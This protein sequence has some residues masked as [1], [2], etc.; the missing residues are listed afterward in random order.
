MMRT[1]HSNI[2]HRPQEAASFAGVKNQA[3]NS[4]PKHDS[5][6]HANSPRSANVQPADVQPDVQPQEW[7]GAAVTSPKQESTNTQVMTILV[8]DDHPMVREGLITIISRQPDMRVVAEATNGREAVEQFMTLRPDVALVDLRMPMMGGIDVVM[9]IYERVPAARLV[10]VTTYQ[11]E[12]DIYR[13]L[14]A[15]ARGYVLK[16]AP[17]E[18]IVECIHA[19][20]SGK[21]WIPPA[22]GAKLAMRVTDRALT[23]RESEVIRALAKGKSNKEIGVALNISE[24]TVKVHVT[25]MLEKLKV[26]GRTEAIAA[27]VKRGLVTID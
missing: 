18:D 24:G 12:E 25:H 20:G 9:S 15:G 17:L 2:D 22:V 1:S 8:A 6:R 7:E 14:Q 10:V 21:T 23:A 4:L 16:D 26:T 11:T 3:R 13:A 19:V 5:L 27:A